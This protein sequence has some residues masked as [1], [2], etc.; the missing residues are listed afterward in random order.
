MGWF[1]R[2][3]E[4]QNERGAKQYHFMPHDGNVH[5]LALTFEEDDYTD[6]LNAVLTEMQ[7]QNHT[8][9]DI[10]LSSASEWF[11]TEH[12]VLILYT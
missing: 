7:S 3:R 9:I 4:R 1:S 2:N 6:E 8:I 12:H 11:F 5:V 10:K